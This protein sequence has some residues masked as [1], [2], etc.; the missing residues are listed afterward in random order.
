MKLTYAKQQV[1][2]TNQTAANH[3][4]HNTKVFVFPDLL[5]HRSLSAPATPLFPLHKSF[6][7]STN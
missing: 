7:E 4:F 5:F 3:K 2:K 1:V 6:D